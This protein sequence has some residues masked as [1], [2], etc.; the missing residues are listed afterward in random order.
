LKKCDDGGNDEIRVTSPDKLKAMCALRDGEVDGKL[1][2]Q[3]EDSDSD[4]SDDS[5]DDETDDEDEPK[6]T[7]ATFRDEE[8]IDGTLAF[9]TEDSDSSDDETDDEEESKPTAV[10]FHAEDGENENLPEPTWAMF[11]GRRRHIALEQQTASI[12]TGIDLDDDTDDMS[13]DITEYLH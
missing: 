12:G 7:V 5:S 1:A 13:S 8:D 4:S 10:K 11:R 9:Q 2:V 3:E 6:P